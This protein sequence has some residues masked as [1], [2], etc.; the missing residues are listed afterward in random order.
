MIS[1]EE[2][3]AQITPGSSVVLLS[4]GLDSAANLA[5]C[6]KYDQVR[7]A[8]TIR[9]GQKAM[10]PEVQAA[11]RLCTYFDV[12]HQIVDLEWLG[13]LGGSSLTENPKEVPKPAE[14]FLDDPERAMATA[15][16]VWVPNRNGVFLN[17]AAA[18][19]ERLKADRILVGFNREE[20]ATF[21]DNSIEFVRAMNESLEYSTQKRVRAYSYTAELTKKEIVSLIRKECPDFPFDLIWS[22]YLGGDAPCGE[23]ES[24]LRLTRALA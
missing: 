6:L 18:Y 12:P 9:Y 23:C 11:Q 19:A 15:K 10:E 4:G 13:R 22:C 5:F 2:Y 1:P 24:C 3:A 14:A 8:L 7:L 20:A 21:P 16:A 17:V